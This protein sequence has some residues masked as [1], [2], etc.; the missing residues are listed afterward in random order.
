MKPN[1]SETYY[2]R[3]LSRHTVSHSVHEVDFR[4][5]G[6]SFEV[7]SEVEAKVDAEVES[8]VEAEVEAKV[9][10]EVGSELEAK[11]EAKVESKAESRVPRGARRW[12][13]D[14]KNF[15]RKKI[16]GPKA[17]KFFGRPSAR[18]QR[19]TGTLVKR[20]RSRHG[21]DRNGRPII[22]LPCD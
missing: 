1:D 19:E 14:P 2:V 15:A 5:S 6:F 4:S 9:E 17:R 20:K 12:G 8:K 13:S 10:A 18:M 16:C 7:E 11:V 22:R 3:E 21:N